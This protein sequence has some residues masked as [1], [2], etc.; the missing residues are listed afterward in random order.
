MQKIRRP[1]KN[2]NA[3]QRL[4]HAQQQPVTNIMDQS[5]PEINP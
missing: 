3:I 2:Q 1:K 5:V 4:P